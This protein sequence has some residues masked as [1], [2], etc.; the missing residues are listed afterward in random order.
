MLQF[1]GSQGVGHDWVTEL[2]WTVSIK[3]YQN[4][5]RKEQ[6]IKNYSWKSAK[7]LLKKIWIVYLKTKMNILKSV[8][9]MCVCWG[10]GAYVCTFMHVSVQACMLIHIPWGGKIC[11]FHQ[12]FIRMYD[13]KQGV[14]KRDKSVWFGYSWVRP[15]KKARV[16][17]IE[18]RER[19]KLRGLEEPREGKDEWD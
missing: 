19:R 15:W 6:L 17:M 13:P 10:K 12:I 11:S 4:V 7:L 3:Y 2:Y 9:F 16:V 8:W 14:Q 18:D 1:M 5:L